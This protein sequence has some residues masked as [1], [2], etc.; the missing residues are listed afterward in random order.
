MLRAIILATLVGATGTAGLAADVA[1]LH[2][3]VY[4]AP[5]AKPLADAT[6]LIHDG[7]IAAVARRVALP[8]G[9]TV[10]ACDACVVMA[11]F[12]NAH[13]HFIEPSWM[14]V[15]TLAP[16]ALERQ[17]QD[18]LTHSG[19]TSVVDTGSDPRVTGELRRRIERGD[20]AGPRIRT[21]GLPLY[22]EHALPYYLDDLPPELRASLPQPASPDEARETVAKNLEAG[23]DI[24]KLFTGSIVKPGQIQ[25]MR[26][27]IAAAAVAESHRRGALVF[28]HATNLAGVRV[29]LDSGVDVLAHAPEVVA[30]IDAALVQE[31]ARKHVVIVPT[32]KLFSRDDDI[33]DIRKLVLDAHRAGIRLVFGTDTGFLTDH[34]VSEEFRQLSLAGL[35]VDDI[36]AML[37]TTPA[38]LFRV[39]GHA[40]R[41]ARGMDGDLTVL[42]SDPATAGVGAFSDVRYTIRG[43]RILFDGTGAE[44]SRR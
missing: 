9:T 29:A 15:A 28:S 35:G 11:G 10:L 26:T 30:G 31:M 17:L 40:G 1:V 36:L 2:A 33:A 41:V 27:D 3:K 24:T 21:A 18:M 39:D 38:A 42:G 22:P 12:W 44:P 13:V 14:G 43:G 32:L 6:V 16:A 8:R 37:T 20:V 7:R 23:A 4:T 5:G 34:D 25:P 19:F